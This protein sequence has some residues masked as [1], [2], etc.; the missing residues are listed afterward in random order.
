M[1]VLHTEE[2]WR[3]VLIMYGELYVI[4]PLILMMPE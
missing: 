3:F 4:T 1:E 2:D